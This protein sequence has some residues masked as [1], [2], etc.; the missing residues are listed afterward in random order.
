MLVLSRKTSERIRIGDDIAITVV[1]ISPYN[2]RLGIDAPRHL[3]VIRE[4]L[5]QRQKAEKDVA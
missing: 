3:T 1:R 4:E 5:E 2:V